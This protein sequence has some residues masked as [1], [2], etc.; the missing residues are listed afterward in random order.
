MDNISPATNHAVVHFYKRYDERIYSFSSTDDEENSFGLSELNSAK[1]DHINDVEGKDQSSIGSFTIYLDQGSDCNSSLGENTFDEE[2]SYETIEE[3][4]EEEEYEEYEEEDETSVTEVTIGEVSDID[5]VVL[6]PNN[7][8][9][10]RKSSS[11]A[12]SRITK[13]STK[14]LDKHISRLGEA[15]RESKRS[16]IWKKMNGLESSMRNLGQKLSTFNF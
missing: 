7:T 5:I 11:R 15:K 16:L 8:I 10:C 3:E 2:L 12:S 6:A 9:F 1:D 4:F 13:A 14:N